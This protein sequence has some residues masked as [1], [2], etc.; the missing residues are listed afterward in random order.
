[1]RGQFVITP[2]AEKVVG[3]AFKS[4][5]DLIHYMIGHLLNNPHHTV[6]WYARRVHPN[7]GMEYRFDTSFG[8]VINDK[9][10]INYLLAMQ[11]DGWE[12]SY[13]TIKERC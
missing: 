1:M 11:E 13:Q 4:L 5:G 3:T 9:K 10:I 7:G 2:E 8:T 12:I 6:G